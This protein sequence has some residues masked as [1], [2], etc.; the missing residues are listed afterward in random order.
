MAV[1]HKTF[2][3]GLTY[4]FIYVIIKEKGDLCMKLM[5]LAT[6]YPFRR[7]EI[8]YSSG[9]STER[10]RAD[11]VM[12]VDKNTFLV[13]NKS[14]PSTPIQKRFLV[15]VDED[16][17]IS[18]LRQRY[19]AE[20][21]KT[22]LMKTKGRCA[23]CGVKLTPEQVTVDHAVPLNFCGC[24]NIVN[25]VPLCRSCNQDKGDSFVSVSS[26]PY[27][28]ERASKTLQCYIVWHSVF[29]T[30][31]SKCNFL[32]GNSKQV[33]IEFYNNCLRG[34]K[35]KLMALKRDLYVARY[36]DLDAV[37]NFLLQNGDFTS[38]AEC[39]NW[40]SEC[41]CRGSIYVLSNGSVKAVV[42]M[43]MS[44]SVPVVTG[45][46]YEYVSINN[47]NLV[48]TSEVLN[49]ISSSM[50]GS[51]L[52]YDIADYYFGDEK[53]V[54]E[55]AKCA[56]LSEVLRN[57]ELGEDG[58]YFKVNKDF[59]ANK[60]KGFVCAM[61]FNLVHSSKNSAELLSVW[62]QE[63][64]RQGLSTEHTSFTLEDGTRILLTYIRG[65]SST[66]VEVSDAINIILTRIQGESSKCV[67]VSGA[68]NIEEGMSAWREIVTY[69]S[70][71]DKYYTILNPHKMGLDI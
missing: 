24:N 27:L 4:C 18:A 20:D 37:Y 25:L 29:N 11:S 26:F 66:D 44:D 8:V 46:F 31:W 33:R 53:P 1:F 70:N 36:S 59:K 69:V 48:L 21:K 71:L 38:E 60:E 51:L 50:S 42:C 17:S 45:L 14:N 28:N 49:H 6:S 23:C 67:K 35:N 40:V 39:K 52:L 22:L 57:A 5:L 30:R 65:E 7:G 54:G 62:V 9:Y 58:S 43:V 3:G 13:H 68:I 19:F 2:K 15:R 56:L 47:S 16:G 41:F 64:I 34:G 63:I 10:V 55:F 61:G 32:N 12:G